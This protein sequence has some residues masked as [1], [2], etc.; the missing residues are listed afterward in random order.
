MTAGELVTGLGYA[1]GAA[2]LYWQART[3]RM[4]TGGFAR[5]ATV[6]V[7]SGIVGAKLA[8]AVAE[9]WP[10]RTPW[11]TVFNPELSGRSIL[12]GVIAG[13][14]GLELAKRTYRI[15]RSTG[16][17]FALALPAGEAVGRIGCFFNGCCYG[18][19][20]DLPWAVWQHGAWRHPAQ[21]YSAAVSATIFAIVATVRYRRD[22]PD[23]ALFRLYLLLFG[24]G[25]F[26]LEFVRVNPPVFGGLTSAQWFCVEIVAMS[27]AMQWLAGRRRPLPGV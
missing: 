6:G 21:L 1:T 11:W 10:F 17:L 24:V 19:V 22:P 12:G 13:W 27:A 3:R 9:G 18:R 25:R 14:L 7:L 15:K 23:G 26:T 5:V 20:C 2:V 8:E 16:D 4:A